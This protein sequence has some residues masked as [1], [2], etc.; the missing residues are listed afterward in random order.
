[1]QIMRLHKAGVQV[2]SKPFSGGHGPEMIRGIHDSRGMDDTIV[3]RTRSMGSNWM[4]SISISQRSE[5]SMSFS[6]APSKEESRP[7]RSGG[8]RPG[9][10]MPA[11]RSSMNPLLLRRKRRQ[12]GSTLDWSPSPPSRT[13][14]RSRIPDSSVPTRRLSRRRRGNSQRQRKA[15]PNGRKYGRSLRTFTNGL[16]T[17]GSIL[18]IKPPVSW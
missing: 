13:A 3:S 9:S 15:L 6:I 12:S 5:F 10:G 8:L 17:D 7:A 1:M 14:R 18:P 4:E 11:S 16:L 2:L